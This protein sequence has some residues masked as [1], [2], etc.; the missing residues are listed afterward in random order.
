M[1]DL[2]NTQQQKKLNILLVGDDCIDIYQYGTVNRISPEAPVPVFSPS[3]SE[4]RPGMA[5]NVHENLLALDCN[6][7]YFYG[8]K[9]KKTRIVDSKSKQ[10]LLRIDKDDTWK[11]PMIFSSAISNKKYDA[12]V[13]SD[14]DKGSLSYE[15]IENLIEIAKKQNCPIFID[16]KKR[17][18]QRFKGAFIKINE[19]E[20]NLVTSLCDTHELIVTMG[21]KGVNYNGK[22]FSA[23]EV[24]V[25]DVC[26]A[27]D[28]FL[29][30]LCYSYLKTKN[31][32]TAIEFAIRASA[33]TVKH[34]GVYAPTLKE[35]LES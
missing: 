19:L 12:I 11:S 18:I 20:R 30:A 31:I 6:V 8:S 21:H 26:G 25:I 23:K 2:T 14:Y 17:D 33:I 10:H 1:I 34:V 28:T 22:V 29:S 3:Y 5:G 24:G 15:S 35:I 7:A 32:E 9:S 16:T 13:V 4:E 27:G